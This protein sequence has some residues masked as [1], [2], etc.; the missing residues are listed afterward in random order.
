MRPH[1]LILDANAVVAAEWAQPWAQARLTVVDGAHP[2]LRRAFA[3]TE[4]VPPERVLT[5]LRLLPSPGS[6]PGQWIVRSATRTLTSRLRA[7]EDLALVPDAAPWS[8]ADSPDTVTIDV[9]GFVV[10]YH[11]AASRSARDAVFDLLELLLPLVRQSPRTA[12]AV[13]RL[14]AGQ[15]PVVLERGASAVY[16]PRTVN[17]RRMVTAAALSNEDM[18]LWDR[19][20]AGGHTHLIDPACERLIPDVLHTKSGKVVVPLGQIV[21]R[22]DELALPMPEGPPAALHVLGADGRWVTPS[23]V[24]TRDDQRWTVTGD[25]SDVD[26]L[27]VRRLVLRADGRTL[28]HDPAHGRNLADALTWLCRVTAGLGGAPVAAGRPPDDP[29]TERPSLP[30]VPPPPAVIDSVETSVRR[31]RRIALDWLGERRDPVD[32]T[33][34]DQVM[35][36]LLRSRPDSAYQP[37]LVEAL[38]R[39]GVADLE[40]RHYGA[41]VVALLV[42]ERELDAKFRKGR[43]SIEVF[44]RAMTT[45][46]AAVN[47]VSSET[48]PWTWQRIVRYVREYLGGTRLAASRAQTLTA[49]DTGGTR[50]KHWKRLADLIPWVRWLGPQAQDLPE[51]VPLAPSDLIDTFMLLRPRQVP[52]LIGKDRRYSRD[53]G[54]RIEPVPTRFARLFCRGSGLRETGLDELADALST[55]LNDPAQ[56]ARRVQ[57]LHLPAALAQELQ[58]RLTQAIEQVTS[59]EQVLAVRVDDPVSAK[60]ML[61]NLSAEH[62]LELTFDESPMRL[63]PLAIEQQGAFNYCARP[64]RI[65]PATAI[66]VGDTQ[67]CLDAERASLSEGANVTLAAL[68]EDLFRGREAQLARLRRSI[69]GTGPRAGSLIFGTRRAGK[70]ALAYRAGQNPRARGFLWIDLSNASESARS[71]FTAWNRAICREI[72]RQARKRLGVALKSD[73]TDFIALLT[74]LDDQLDGGPPAVVILDE[75]DMLLLPGQSSAGRRAAGRLGNLAWNN[76]VVIGT[77]Q[78]FHRSVHEFKNWSSIECPAD[79]SWADGVTYFFGP[80]AD[81][82]AGPRVEWLRRAGV[83]PEDYA[84][85]IVPLVGLRPYFWAQLRDRIEGHVNEDCASRL[86]PKD[87]L[88]ERLDALASGDPFLNA[89]LDRGGELDAEER[90]RR[91]LFSDDERRILA[92][93]AVM[94]AKKSDL[95]LTEATTLGGDKAVSELLD[96]AYLS[97][98]DNGTRLRVAVPIYHRFLRAKATELL[99]VVDSQP[100]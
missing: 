12:S 54:V 64:R 49:K 36:E 88:R 50:E 84:N 35:R 3:G 95:M 72:T 92:R 25:T 76:L 7:P 78:R 91:D 53:T 90:R 69:G 62:T 94:P 18:V 85:E 30:V 74:D 14:F 20:A 98:A 65:E 93:F 97:L 11:C 5:V 70:S 73:G 9:D 89:V 8:A 13:R 39:V 31:T 34:V 16:L 10:E 24:V 42:V 87:V 68:P 37:A 75:L 99:T 38:G 86:V 51:G 59:P 48:W 41:Q 66:V 47:S 23:V 45:Y 1:Y 71:N 46:L 81:R 83:G 43:F 32:R 19:H 6:T 80:L 28:V 17:H 100:N 33:A 77:V 60:V 67:I 29:M 44:S 52:V 56:T 58:A 61:I 27:P 26:T 82:T 57:A 96:R 55:L 40:A 15:L 4:P 63:P 79:L 2:A 22:G 21:R